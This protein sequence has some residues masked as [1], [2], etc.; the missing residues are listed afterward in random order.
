L[1]KPNTKKGLV[2]WLKWQS[3]FLG[4]R[5]PEFKPQW[6]RKKETDKF[7]ETY[8]RPR[9]THKETENLNRPFSNK[10]KLRV[11]WLP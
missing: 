1:K 9:L 3:A 6:H 4:N 2:E 10:E 5:G 8:N 11:R 7:L